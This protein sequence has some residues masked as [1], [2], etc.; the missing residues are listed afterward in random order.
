M[1]PAQSMHLRLLVILS[2]ALLLV[3]CLGK[4]SAQED[5]AFRM[6]SDDLVA[7]VDAPLRPA[8]SLS[9]DNRWMALLESKV[10]VPIT[11]LAKPELKLAGIELNP[12]NFSRSAPGAGFTSM[13]LQAVDGSANFVV[14]GLPEGRIQS[15]MWSP[16]GAHMAFVIEAQ[17]HL[18]L[19]VLDVGEQSARELSATPLNGVI[20]R[21]PFSWSRDSRSL[22]INAAVNAG[23]TPPAEDEI[24]VPVIQ[25][26]TGER[27]PARTFQNLLRTPHDE[28]LFDFY[29]T[30]E[31]RR[32]GLDGAEQTLTEPAVID[33]FTP[34]PDGRYWLLGTVQHPYSYRVPLNRFGRH[35]DVIDNDGS[36]VR[37]VAEQTLAENIPQGFDS[38]R[39]GPRNM[40]WRDDVAAE[41]IWAEAQD[42]GDMKND[43]PFHDHVLAWAAPFEGEPR[44]FRQVERRYAAISFADGERMMLIDWRFSDRQL[45]VFIADPNDPDAEPRLFNE[46]SF[47]DA[48]RDPGTPVTHPNEFGVEVIHVHEGQFVYLTGIGASPEGNIP[49][50]DR[51]DLESGE[52]ERL[53]QSESP[54]YERVSA[55]LDES[56]NRFVTLRESRDEQ[57]NFYL[58]DRIAGTLEPITDFPHPYPTFRGI[59]KEL[60]RYTRED[61]VE[62]TGTLYLPPGH[63]PGDGPLPVLLWAYPLEF[64]DRE[65]AGQVRESP[66]A[67]NTI[68]FWGPLPHLANGI[69]VFDDPK[70]PIVGDDDRLPNDSF[71]AQLVSS[72]QAAVDVLVERGIADRDQIAIA[73][74]SYGAFMVANLLAHSDIFATGIARSGAYNRS[75]TPFG[76]QGE[77]RDF[78]EGQE[79]YASM[80]PFFHAEKINEPMLMIHGQDDPNSGTFP[81]QSERMFSALKGLGKDARLVML[82]FEGHGYRARESI[83]HVLWE[84]EQWL[85]RYLDGV[86]V[87]SEG[88]TQLQP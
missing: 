45:R 51:Y 58:R 17:D 19:W 10:V 33:S 41:L 77:E 71:R 50:L 31:L 47:N 34:S 70:M 29:G 20:T 49:F 25:V 36:R 30:G 87:D 21:T 67:F 56:A 55:V 52:T 27:A 61:G 79:I 83:L 68:G 32:I 15:P 11:D 63:E 2:T 86:R 37:R 23:G 62:L 85:A 80:S 48:Y 74:H 44:L 18:R 40:Q 84:Q 35:F 7:L 57:P 69:A 24:V 3:L 38:V 14:Q 65:V 82:P 64:R 42:G 28:A 66:Y 9:P 5:A 76:F 8:A 26:T 75:L 43:V 12:R 78:W 73:G 4:V 81:M 72:A 54:Y 60:I 1:K 22:V 13:R 59:D 16:D 46:R 6:P 39:T 53:W 88:L